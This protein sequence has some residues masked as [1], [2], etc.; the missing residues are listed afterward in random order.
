MGNKFWKEIDTA[1]L[2]ESILFNTDEGILEGY[3]DKNR[4]LNPTSFDFHGCGCCSGHYPKPTHWAEIP[5][6]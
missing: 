5:D 3:L 1:P 6:E 4:K 2:Y